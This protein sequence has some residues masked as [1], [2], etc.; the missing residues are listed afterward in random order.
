VKAHLETEQIEHPGIVLT[1]ESEEENLMLDQLWVYGR[2][3]MFSREGKYRQ[4]T[5]APVPEAAKEAADD[6]S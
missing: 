6:G 4:L 1:A 3:A 2:P 5:I